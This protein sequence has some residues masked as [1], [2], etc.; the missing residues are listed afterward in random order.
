MDALLEEA[1]RREMSLRE[2]LAWLCAAEETRKDQL[3]INHG[4]FS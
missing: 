2:A 1:A 3:H 4:I